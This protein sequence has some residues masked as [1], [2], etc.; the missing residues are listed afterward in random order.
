MAESG[1]VGVGGGRTLGEESPE[2]KK[3]GALLRGEG[4]GGARE[5]KGEAAGAVE[6]EPARVEAEP[7]KTPGATDGVPEDGAAGEGEE[8]AAA[9]PLTVAELAK[10]LGVNTGELYK[11]LMVPVD[12][13]TEGERVSLEALR[14]G[15]VEAGKLERERETFEADADKRSL[16]FMQ[17]RAE[18]ERL[19]EL[20]LPNAP[21]EV[22]DKFQGVLL[23]REA[24]ERALLLEAVPEWK[25][26]AKFAADRSSMIEFLKPWGFSAADVY[27]IGDHRIAR[28]VRDMSREAKRKAD[29]ERKA[30]ERG[31]GEVKKGQAP[32]G[33]VSVSPLRVRL[34]NIVKAGRAAQTPEAKTQAIGAL[35]RGTQRGK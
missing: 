30:R 21:R 9:G 4:D 34:A 14:K 1:E 8:A 24:R 28:F 32:D 18:L 29:A 27:A 17:A 3:I 33:R 2:V 31:N 7:G 11:E 5:G 10:T 16:E 12:T 15:Y 23:Q 20:I 35:L 22:V 26:A 13:G 19:G 25:D 6:G